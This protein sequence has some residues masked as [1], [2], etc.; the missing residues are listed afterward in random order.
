MESKFEILPNEI[1]TQNISP[2]FKSN[3]KELS[4]LSLTNKKFY[5]LFQP[6]RLINTLLHHV[7]FGNHDTVEKKLRENPELMVQKSSVIDPSGRYFKHISAFELVLWTLD[8]RY[9]GQMMLDCVPRDKKGGKIR[10]ELQIQFNTVRD[11]G[12]TYTFENNTV[13]ESHFNF[14]PLIDALD[15]Y[16]QNYTP[17]TDLECFK[18]LCS[19]VG[20]EQFKLPVHVRHH[21]CDP[22]ESFTPTPEFTKK[23]LQRTLTLYNSLGSEEESEEECIERIWNECLNGLGEHFIIFRSGEPG[24]VW[25]STPLEGAVLGDC[26]ALVELHKQRTKDMELLQETL[27]CLTIESEDIPLP[28][29]QAL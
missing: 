5:T 25:T 15:G 29:P 21:Y 13:T 2:L 22:D 17:W 16:I 6:N 4:N 19:V 1:Y 24:A 18:Y 3:S 9:M 11:I 10:E 12:V 20:K 14:K 26:N 8:V 7:V 23:K 28:T 27:K